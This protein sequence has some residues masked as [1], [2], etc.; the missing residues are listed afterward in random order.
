MYKDM[1]IDKSRVLIKLAATY[2]GIQA[3]EQLE[4]DGI[5]CNLTLIFS[6]VQ[7]I[8]CAQR[9]AHLISPFPGRILDWNRIKEGRTEGVMPEDDEGVIAVKTMYNYYKVCHDALLFFIYL[10]N[11]F[12]NSFFLQTFF[13]IVSF[14]EVPRS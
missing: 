2:E 8:A 3:A 13:C 5:Q 6:V 9:G 1:G 12:V 4:K 7:A 11:Y 14:M 10:I